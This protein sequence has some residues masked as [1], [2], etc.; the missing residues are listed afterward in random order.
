MVVKSLKARITF[1]IIT[2]FIGLSFIIGFTYYRIKNIQAIAEKET[3]LVQRMNQVQ[4]IKFSSLQIQQFLTDASLTFDEE[5]VEEAKNHEEI[6]KTTADTLLQSMPFLNVEIDA[7]KNDLAQF[8]GTGKSMF[9]AYKNEG[10]EAGDKIMKG[11]SGFDNKS[12]QLTASLNKINDHIKNLFEKSQQE[13]SSYIATSI[14]VL[15]I[16]SL[17][18]LFL[19]CSVLISIAYHT[20]PLAKTAE[21]LAEASQQ[22]KS[23]SSEVAHTSEDL[24]EA[25]LLQAASVQETSASIE[26]ISSM[27][28][29][30]SETARQSLHLAEESLNKAKKGQ[31]VVGHMAQ[32]IGDI[33]TSNNGIILQIDET[34]HE[35][36]HIVKIINEIGSKTKVIN[37]I[38]FQTKLLSFNASVE[39]ARAGEQGKGFAVVAEEVGKLAAMSGA[40]ALEISNIVEGSIVTVEGIVKNSKTKIGKLVLDSKE[41]V[42]L[43][44]KAANECENVL[45]E[46]VSSVE[47]V[48]KMITE[49]SSASQ[50][51]AKGVHEINKALA[52]LDQVT[53]K[54]V[55]SASD[56]SSIARTLMEQA[57]K[58]DLNVGS[59]LQVIKG[60]VGFEKKMNPHRV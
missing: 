28:S 32:A 50:E 4:V 27:V 2:S 1:G 25:G 39:A 59:L 45:S 3:E 35:I 17:I 41:K 20:K 29:A 22:I 9:H 47:N 12:L 26:E 44:N 36:E 57:E 53:H 38:V 30:N 54:N 13:L 14:I 49:V 18:T 46:I 5:A 21:L 37:D 58:L 34:N 16:S 60:A 33:N 51:Q 42:D 10:K 6:A 23:A 52:Q 24:S 31:E 55:S 43:G 11:E 40:A 56:S 7:F 48:S 15:L 19:I 8:S